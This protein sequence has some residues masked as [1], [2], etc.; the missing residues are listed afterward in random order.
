LVEQEIE[1]DE[2]TEQE[3]KETYASSIED[4]DEFIPEE[5]IDKEDEVP[6]ESQIVKLKWFRVLLISFILTIFTVGVTLIVLV[7]INRNRSYIFLYS[8]WFFLVEC[9]IFF[10]FGGCVGTF[11]QSFTISYLRNRFF[12]TEKITGADTK[13]AIASSYTYV[14]VGLLLGLASFFAWLAVS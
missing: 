13:L 11:R 3:K 12:K 6:F 5:T 14:F 4:F 9:G 1:N 2:I 10:T 7:I 8:P